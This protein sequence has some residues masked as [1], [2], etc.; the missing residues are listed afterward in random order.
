MTDSHHSF[1]L[2][3]HKSDTAF[4]G[5]TIVIQRAES[6]DP[7][8]VFLLYITSWD[9]LFPFNSFLWLRSDGSIPTH[10]WFVSWLHSH[11]PDSIS[12][13]SLRAGGATSL[14]VVGISTDHIQAMGHWLSDSFCIYIRKNLAL[15]H[16]L[17]FNGQSIHDVPSAPFVSI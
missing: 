5:N 1:K 17:L 4:E 11:F 14:T 2:Q 8:R 16:A 13:H 15:L 10:V 6:V 3:H 9:K 12:G 7:Q